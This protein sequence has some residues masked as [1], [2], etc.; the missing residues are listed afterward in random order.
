[1]LVSLACGVSLEAAA[2]SAVEGVMHGEDVWPHFSW[3][4]ADG[5]REAFAECLLHFADAALDRS[6]VFRV[7][8]R[9]VERDDPVPGED[10][11]NGGMV[12]RA[13]IIP[14]KEERG[15]VFAEEVPQMHGDRFAFGLDGHKRCEAVPRA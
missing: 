5:L 1:M 11:V 13:P 3:F 4:P 12:K 2:G 10:L 8:C 14:L 9:A 6:V 7:V 15:A